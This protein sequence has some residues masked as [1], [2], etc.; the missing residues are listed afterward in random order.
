LQKRVLRQTPIENTALM[1]P[2]AHARC[3]APANLFVV[4]QDKYGK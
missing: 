4:D 2:G 1:A 3:Y